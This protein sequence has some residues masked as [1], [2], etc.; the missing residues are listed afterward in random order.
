MMIQNKL[1]VAKMNDQA[2]DVA[3]KELV[4]LNPKMYSFLVDDSIEYKKPNDVKKNV[5]AA[6][7]HFQYKEVLLNKNVWEI[8][9]IASKLKIK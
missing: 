7:G 8:L 9:W 5:F 3:I 6:I 4:G 2:A 1:V